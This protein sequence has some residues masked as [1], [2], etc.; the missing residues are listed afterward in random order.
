[1]RWTAA[2]APQSSADQAGTTVT[3]LPPPL[4]SLSWPGLGATS[5]PAHGA[6]HHTAALS[7]EMCH[8][9]IRSCWVK[10]ESKL[11]TK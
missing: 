8:L 2:R 6:T 1:M 9:C 10:K 7:L 5:L 3:Y 11:W 4:S